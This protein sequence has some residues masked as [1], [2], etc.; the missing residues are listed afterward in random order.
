M[1][2]FLPVAGV[3]SG[4]LAGAFFA[5]RE[6][7]SE[8]RALL[9]ASTALLF[10]VVTFFVMEADF[11]GDFVDF[12][13]RLDL[14]LMISICLINFR[15]RLPSN[16]QTN[17]HVWAEIAHPCCHSLLMD[18]RRSPIE[19]RARQLWL[20]MN[21]R[22]SPAR[23]GGKGLPPSISRMTP[24]IRR[25]PILWRR[26]PSTATKLLSGFIRRF[27]IEACGHQLWLEH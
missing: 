3:A 6:L 16:W 17:F 18:L 25:A 22:S 19:A 14:S 1:D 8:V 7:A 20:A 4:L 26:R 23:C 11:F 27:R 9:P 2:A 10:L 12:F 13:S 24:R 21:P 5:L 15:P